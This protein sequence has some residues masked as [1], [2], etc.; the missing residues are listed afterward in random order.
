M[1]GEEQL[2]LLCSRALFSPAWICRA[3]MATSSVM[4]NGRLSVFL[5]LQVWERMKPTDGAE[6]GKAKRRKWN[7][8]GGP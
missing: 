2:G 6:W 3:L 1:V 5:D 8:R 7:S 4:S